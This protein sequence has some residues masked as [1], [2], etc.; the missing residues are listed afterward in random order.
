[1][2]ALEIVFH[3]LTFY[4]SL[5]FLSDGFSAIMYGPKE[6][7]I[8]GNALAVQADKPFRGLSMFGNDFLKK[9]QGSFL[10]ANILEDISFVDSPGTPLSFLSG[11]FNILYH[12]FIRHSPLVGVL[13]GEKQRIGRQYDFP[14]VIEWFAAR[15]DMIL[16]LFDAHKLDISDE[17]KRAIEALR[18]NDDK[19]RCVL[20]K[21]DSVSGQQLMR[22]YGALMW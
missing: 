19:I 1:L 16:L 2:I 15:C 14:A 8:P 17:F 22:V 3:S 4:F 9:F 21:A 12:S 10:P 20:N 7:L 13:S 5:L 11:L 18:G 6:M